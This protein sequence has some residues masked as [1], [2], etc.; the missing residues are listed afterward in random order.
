[1]A[2]C[3]F[4]PSRPSH[5]REN[6]IRQCGRVTV[7]DGPLRIVRR[8]ADTTVMAHRSRNRRL[9]ARIGLWLCLFVLAVWGLTWHKAVGV[10]FDNRRIS[11][12]NGHVRAWELHTYGQP[13]KGWH[14]YVDDATYHVVHGPG[15]VES[16]LFLDGGTQIV[17]I[18]MAIPLILLAFPTAVLWL[19]GR[20]SPAG[21]CQACGYN[22]AGNVSGVCPECGTGV[23]AQ[24]SAG[25]TC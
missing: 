24:P 13:F 11:V 17:T 16:A 5:Y 7:A 18:S 25:K 14:F 6:E 4:P 22:L 1:V 9:A 15:W 2:L 19:P 23:G 8:K 20:R 21:H 10:G 3:R 12:G